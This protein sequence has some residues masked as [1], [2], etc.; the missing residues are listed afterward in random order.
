MKFIAFATIGIMAI[1]IL[2]FNPSKGE[3]TKD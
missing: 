2:I 3:T 1:F